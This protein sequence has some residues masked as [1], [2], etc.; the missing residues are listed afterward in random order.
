MAEAAEQLE[1]TYTREE[2]LALEAQSDIKHEFFQGEIFAMSGGTYNHADISGNI[3]AS[4]KFKLR[5]RSC[6][7]MNS[8]MRIHTP[9]GLDTYPDVSVFCGKPDLQDKQRTLLNPV[10]IIEVLSP[11]TSN[12]DRGNKFALYRAI[13][14]LTAYVLVDSAQVLVEHYR[15]SA[16]NEWILRE[17]RDLTDNVHLAG[18]EATL[19]LAEIYE[20]IAFE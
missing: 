8:D 10:V 11:S 12:Y 17:Y 7:P 6:R 19:N 18:I 4:L 13:P 14:T 2:Y 15:R 9:S 3:Y 16:D 5:S 1:K 20:T